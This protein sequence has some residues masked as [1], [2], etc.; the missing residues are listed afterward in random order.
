MVEVNLIGL[1]VGAILTLTA[2]TLHL[3]RGTGWT[4]TTDISGEVLERRAESVPE[5]GFPEPMNRAIGG[6]GGGAVAAGAVTGEEGAELE[7]EAEA[8]RLQIAQEYYTY[9]T[10]SNQ[11]D[12]PDE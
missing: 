7:G 1:S 4:P 5:T 3:S 6:G 8:M 9:D 2:V 11:D 12:S 10:N